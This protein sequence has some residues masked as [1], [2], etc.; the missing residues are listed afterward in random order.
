MYYSI[1][2]RVPLLDYRLIE[3]C[4][5]L[6]SNDH[7]DSDNNYY[8]DTDNRKIILKNILKNKLDTNLYNRNKRG[9]SLPKKLANEYAKLG[10]GSINKLKNRGIIKSTNFKKGL[11]GR[12]LIYF[13][14]S[15]HA[16]ELWFQQY[17]DTNI[18]ND[19]SNLLFSKSD[20]YTKR[21]QC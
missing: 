16:L 6:T 12:D 15:C 5:T 3:R 11:V 10:E 2:A 4:L 20:S 14:N 18:V 21:I 7:I 8:K 17:V 19:N 1:E 9:F 13:K